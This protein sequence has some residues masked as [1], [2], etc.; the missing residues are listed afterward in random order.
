MRVPSGVA[1][2]EVL[3]GQGK[4]SRLGERWKDKPALVVFLRHFACMACTEHVA[5]LSPWLDEIGRLGIAIVFVGNGAPNFIE[6]FVERNR[7][8]DKPVE[9]VTDPSLR[10]FDAAKLERS[11]WSNLS[12]AA[13]KNFARALLHGFRQDHI[14]GNGQQ[15]GGAMLVQPDGEL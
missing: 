5:L 8:G 10:V 3:D 15:Q 7:L 12:P 9:I 4:A 13:L 14:E 2:A 1:E 11:R 6:G